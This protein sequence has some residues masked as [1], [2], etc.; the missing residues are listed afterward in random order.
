MGPVVTSTSRAIRSQL[1]LIFLLGVITAVD[2]FA[3][4]MY[5]PSFPSIQAD[6]N[7]DAGNMQWSLSLFLIGLG[8]GQA[9]FGPI[10]DRYGRRG[11]LLLGLTLFTV[12]SA[13]VALA[14]SL[15]VFLVGRA[16]QGIG[17][18][19]TVVI[20]R[21]IVA[22][23]FE[24]RDSAKVYSMLMQIM[25]IGPIIAPLLGGFI[26]EHTVW[27]WVFWILFSLG[28]A[29][30]LFTLAVVDE[31]LS[32]DRR[33]IESAF[34][35]FRSYGALFANRLFLF[36]SLTGSCVI[37]GLFTYVGSSAFIF[38]DYYQLEPGTFSYI[39]AGIAV[40]LMVL[41][42]V[43]IWLLR[44]YSE[45]A[46]LT[47]G[48]LLYLM[49][50]CGFLVTV[51]FQMATLI[52]T[53]LLLFVAVASLSLIMG[54]LTSLAM[55]CVPRRA[56]SASAIFGVTQYVISGLAGVLAG[57]LFD[58]SMLPA[59]GILAVTGV[60]ACLFLLEAWRAV[61]THFGSLENRPPYR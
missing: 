35:T 59:A 16:I 60:S 24:A 44:L 40:G 47:F 52:S 23:R 56:G 58:G 34:A 32:P 29:C 38:T 54:N 50:T 1:P 30:L 11:P 9:I 42:Q 61:K 12:A 57:M 20:P 31:S 51:V 49:G 5:I 8:A 4:D 27:Q 25:T 7:A 55:A 33:H 39:F 45:V 10:S 43:N 41:A 2:A 17:A 19:A 3:I 46:L 53:T 13:M 26:I 48:L 15:M 36:Y 28:L 18:S 22:D 6:L 14:P 21:A 37:A